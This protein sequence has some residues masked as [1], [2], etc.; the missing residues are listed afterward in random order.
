MVFSTHPSSY[1]MGDASKE[2]D[3]T[4]R[5]HPLHKVLNQKA[6]PACSKARAQVHEQKTV[7]LWPPN[8]VWSENTFL[9]KRHLS[10]K[11]VR[12]CPFQVYVRHV[13]TAPQTSRC[14]TRNASRCKRM[15]EIVEQILDVSAIYCATAFAATP[16]RF[17]R[18]KNLP[19]CF[20]GCLITL[21]SSFL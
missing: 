19:V 7:V 5:T 15:H 10:A 4:T 8:G 21:V 3:C 2:E 14:S 6:V 1:R 20:Q 11:S 17:L 18:L 9:P 13:R 16:Q 12:V